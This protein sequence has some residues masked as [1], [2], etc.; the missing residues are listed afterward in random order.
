MNVERLKQFKAGLI[1]TRSQ[2]KSLNEQRKKQRVFEHVEVMPLE[3][4]VGGQ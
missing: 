4:P 3:M 1:S 2:V